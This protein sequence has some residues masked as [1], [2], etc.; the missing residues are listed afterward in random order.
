MPAS[1]GRDAASALSTAISARLTEPSAQGS[2]LLH[3]RIG[4]GDRAV[5]RLVDRAGRMQMIADRAFG[6]LRE[7][8]AALVEQR[9]RLLVAA[10]LAPE[11]V[12]FSGHAE[13]LDAERIDVAGADRKMLVAPE[14][15]RQR[16]DLEV[17]EIFQDVAAA[18]A[19]MAEIEEERAFRIAF[20]RRLAD[21]LEE[22]DLRLLGEF[23]PVFRVGP[24]EALRLHLR[25]R[26]GAD[27]DQ[28]KADV[29]ED[30]VAVG[31]EL[32]R[33][34]RP[35]GRDSRDRAS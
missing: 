15:G 34:R 21:A 29:D 3:M 9:L 31:E 13:E 24:V 20:A 8:R 33:P 14:G 6:A 10:D 26:P 27:R 1:R 22:L 23:Q 4:G 12:E 28:R 30:A 7:H 35:G 5:G 11:V 17:A 2:Q 32:D 18:A 16:F 19:D 25:L